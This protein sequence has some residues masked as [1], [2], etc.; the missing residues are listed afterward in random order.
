MGGGVWKKIPVINQL[1]KLC[2]EQADLSLAN[3][4]RKLNSTCRAELNQINKKLC[5][6]QAELN[7]DNSWKINLIQYKYTF[8]ILT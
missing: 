6:Q 8:I 4:R 3:L 5:Q 7:L 2:P 1:K